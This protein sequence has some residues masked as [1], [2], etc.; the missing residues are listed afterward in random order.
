MTLHDAP[1]EPHHFAEK[2]ACK[3]GSALQHAS[4]DPHYFPKEA[5]CNTV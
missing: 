2:A 3:Y 4:Q 5:G 1:E